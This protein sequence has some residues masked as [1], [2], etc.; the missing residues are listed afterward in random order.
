[1]ALN[2]SI[3]PSRIEAKSLRFSWKG[4]L[5]FSGVVVRDPWDKPLATMKRATLDRGLLSLIAG[6]AQ[7]V[8]LTL[9]GVALDAT[10]R[11][12]GSLD[13]VEAIAPLFKREGKPPLLEQRRNKSEMDLTVVVT[14]GSLRLSSPELI[15]PIRAQRF[16]A[17][18]H[19]PAGP[20][21]ATCEVTLAEPS[22]RDTATLSVKGEL[23]RGPKPSELAPHVISV[24]GARWPW[25]ISASGVELKGRLDGKLDARRRDG[26][27]EIT[28]EPSMRD[29][30]LGGAP[31]GGDRLRLDRVQLACDLIQT[32]GGWDLRHLDLKS[33]VAVLEAGKTF[34]ASPTGA[35]VAS[36]RITGQIDVAGL[37]RQLTRTF[38][39]RDGLTLERGAAQVELIFSKDLGP[40]GRRISFD[41]R[42]SHLVARENGRAI[43]VRTPATLSGAV[44]QHDEKIVVKHLKAQGAGFV[45]DAAGDVDRGVK[46]AAVLDLN[47]WQASYGRLFQLGSVAISGQ[48][49]VVGDYRRTKEQVYVGRIAAELSGLNI[50]GM[51]RDPIIHNALRVDAAFSGPASIAGLPGDWEKSRFG[52][53]AEPFAVETKLSSE[54]GSRALRV[55]ELRV[56]WKPTA[57]GAP[58][59]AGT[60]PAG[61]I[62]FVARG[63]LDLP[64][65]RLELKAFPESLAEPFML[66][67]AGA[68]ISGLNGSGPLQGTFSLTGDLAK[69]EDLLVS[70][71]GMSALGLEGSASISCDIKTSPEG[72]VLAVGALETSNAT[73]PGAA[74][75]KRRALVPMT[76]R[77]RAGMPAGA[78]RLELQDVTFDCRYATMRAAGTVTDPAG[79]RLADLRGLIAPKWD[80]IDRLVASS[81]EP[82]ARVRVHSHPIRVRGAMSGE[83]LARLVENL[84]AELGVDR[85][86]GNAFGVQLAPTN[87]VIRAAKGH[88]TIDPIDTTIN[89]GRTRLRPVVSGID[90]GKLTLHLSPGDSVE[91][92]ELNDELSQRLLSYAIPV[93]DNKTRAKGRVSVRV[94]RAEIPLVGGDARKQSAGN[95]HVVLDEVVSTAGGL[96]SELFAMTGHRINTIRLHEVLEVNVANGRVHQ[97]GLNIPLGNDARV[98]IDGSV[99]FDQTL[100]LRARL[101]ADHA[102]VGARQEVLA[103]VVEALK[104]GIP[105]AGTI[106]R[107]AI[108]RKAVRV[109]LRDLGKSI[110]KHSGNR[111]AAEIFDELVNP[112]KQKIPNHR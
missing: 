90:E 101:V 96:A 45:A 2:R 77:V 1:M 19:F 99:G 97:H 49:R 5:Q 20:E 57:A 10:R 12:D 16:A 60:G 65:G 111:Q 84:D 88:V 109:G 15:E 61:A 48:G 47:T 108:D 76:L 73:I 22:A 66:N 58:V 62:H 51:T 14:Q 41:A 52:L 70:T 80:A 50:Q 21:P 3:A 8:K 75:P 40:E 25:S 95:G 39:L 67:G 89:G 72:H 92:L 54:P 26:R 32:F 110:L 86:E 91:S 59:R 105:V 82:R 64:A 100:A 4:P 87:I 98:A 63:S 11:E 79:V 81:V 27:W 6:K 35:Q 24:V 103:D 93:W 104:V 29:F 46:L 33:P 13:L 71:A 7:R 78:N 43:E 107:P 28:G 38:R 106:S 112:P 68:N 56:D 42:L 18:L 31:F 23:S 44:V 53:K 55:D 85:L 9:D 94:E 34:V 74:R 36:T 37:A 83:S 69:L 102:L 30:E 17:T